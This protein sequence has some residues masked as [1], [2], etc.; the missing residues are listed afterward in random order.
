MVELLLVFIGIGGG[1][2]ANPALVLSRCRNASANS[3]FETFSVRGPN[4][5]WSVA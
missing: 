1:T 2:L 3:S 4:R 5:S